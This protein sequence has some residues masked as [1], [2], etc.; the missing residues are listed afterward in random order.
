MIVSPASRGHDGTPAAF[1]VT[2]RNWKSDELLMVATG[3]AANSDTEIDANT[4]SFKQY[5]SD[6]IPF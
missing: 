4:N 1:T 3:E 2:P 6:S 5:T